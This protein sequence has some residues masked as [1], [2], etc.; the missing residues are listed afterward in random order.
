MAIRNNYEYIDFLCYG[1]NYNN[2][3]I[4]AGFSLLDTRNNNTIIPNYFEPFDKKNVPLYTAYNKTSKNFRQC[5]A[6]GDQDR[7]NV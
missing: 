2:E 6:D 7:P 5:K 1:F 3:L 4:N